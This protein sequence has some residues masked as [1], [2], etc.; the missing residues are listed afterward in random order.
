MEQKTR[1][2][3]L[4]VVTKSTIGG[5]QRYVYDLATNLDRNTFEVQVAVGGNGPLK[6]ILESADITVHTITGM[7]RDM[8]FSKELQSWWS[9]ATL[10]K[11]YDPDILHLNSSKAG[12]TG[13]FLGRILGV[14]RV[15]FT[16]HGWA[17][18]EHR[19]W[20]SKKLI[21]LLHW[22]TVLLSHT[23]I[24]VSKETKTQL[25]GPWVQH[26]MTVIRNGLATP[27][28][29]SRTDARAQLSMHEPRLQ[30]YRADTWSISIGEL[31]HIKNHHITIAAIAALT[32]KTIR[33]VIIGGGEEKA[34]LENLIQEHGVTDQVFLLGTVPNAAT[35]L[36]AADV[37]VLPSR[38]EA[39]P[40]ALL[41]AVHAGV[42]IIASNVGGIPEVIT[43][44]Q[45]SMLIPPNDSDALSDAL[46][47]LLHRPTQNTVHTHEQPDCTITTMVNNTIQCYT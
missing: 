46:H 1:K 4:F 34:H 16:A 2:K 41:E 13:A 21:T 39:L 35:L 32:D 28:F 25:P 7:Q 9:L 45:T 40:Y 30:A 47:T 20:L 42:P 37:F 18:N 22:L 6:E 36:K 11:D 38:S 5:A 31:H 27:D 29:L 24:A 26:K 12:G 10:I 3:V 17:F 15:I 14:P 44:T 23:T 43:E 19:S 8:S 33:H